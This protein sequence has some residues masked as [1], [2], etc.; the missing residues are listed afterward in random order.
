MCVVGNEHS[1]IKDS[2]ASGTKPLLGQCF[3]SGVTSARDCSTT[4]T[5]SWDT[6][7]CFHLY[8]RTL[9]QYSAVSNK[10]GSSIQMDKLEMLSFQVTGA[11]GVDHWSKHNSPYPGFSLCACASVLS[12]LICHPSLVSRT[13]C[14]RVWQT[15]L[16]ARSFSPP[17]VSSLRSTAHTMNAAG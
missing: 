15:D 3:Y 14:C 12:S 8:S 5:P 7:G 16:P 1:Y 17:K 6:C 13:K 2:D 4:A 9:P 10:P 11:I